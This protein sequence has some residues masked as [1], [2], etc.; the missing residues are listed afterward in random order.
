MFLSRIKAPGTWHPSSAQLRVD[1]YLYSP[2]C[3]FMTWVQLLARGWTVWWLNYLLSALDFL[4]QS[5]LALGPTHPPAH[6][7]QV[8][9][10]GCKVAR[11]GPS[12]PVLWWDFVVRVIMVSIATIPPTELSWIQ[13]LLG[14]KDFSRPGSFWGPPSFLYS[15]FRVS[16]QGL[17]PPGR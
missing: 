10:P 6:W 15:G 7:E 8:F 5:R 12:W 17:K 1:Q 2:V 13:I 9:F 16:F 11:V 3:A 4:V 14:K